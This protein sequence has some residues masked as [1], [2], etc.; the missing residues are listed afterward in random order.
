MGIKTDARNKK[1]I[2]TE[3]PL[4]TTGIILILLQLKVFLNVFSMSAMP[5]LTLATLCMTNLRY[6]YMLYCKIFVRFEIKNSCL[7]HFS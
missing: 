7:F 5:L 2:T 1:C 6:I 3:S 4:Q